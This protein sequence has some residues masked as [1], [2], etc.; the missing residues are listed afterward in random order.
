ME[1]LNSFMTWIFKSR[2]GQI[3]K[4]KQEPHSVQR[5][6]L[7]EL[8]EAAKH[9]EF[10]KTHHFEK[11]KSY[12]DFA[13]RVPLFDYESFTPYLEKNIKGKQQ[14]FWPSDIKWFA[15][16]SGTT[17]G[18]SKYI[19]VSD[20]SLEEC[21]YKGGKD[22]VSLY[23][24]NFPD[25]KV[26]TGKSLTVGGALEKD[27]LHPKGIARAGDVS[28]V[29]MHNLPI[30]AQFIRT[31]S[32]ETALMSDWEAKIERM[33]RETMDENVT[34]IAG[35]PTWTIVL[36]QRILELKKASHILE[37]WPNLEVFFHGAVA[38]GPYRNLFKELIPS[39]KMRYMETYNASEGFFG[40]QDQP[41][42]DELLLLL[43]YGIFY[44]FILTEDLEKENPRV[45]SL[46]GVEVGKNY[47]L[48]I[49]TNGGL[50]RYKIGD[51]VKFTSVLP[52]RFRIS[53]RT[54][55]FIN[56]FGEE[57]IVENAEAAISYACEQTGAT[58]TNFTAAPIYFEDSQSK[59]AHEWVVEFK[60][61]PSDLENFADILD[62]HLRE[63]NSDYD[64]K[65]H[66]NLALQRL[67]LHAAPVG[68]FESWLA[69]KGKLGGQHKVPR[70]SN[71]RE[72]MEEILAM[73]PQAT[74]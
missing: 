62:Q 9:T 37:V 23:V 59:G 49:S 52:Y 71:S 64:A 47:A 20:E 46:E 26:F 21:H 36:L 18:R 7:V 17:A 45:I 6:T 32:L 60:S 69:K 22:M 48:L 8:L 11:I 1:V 70:L 15:K 61:P 35:V 10:G 38:F 4:F 74:Q 33:A 30:W 5:T 66:K 3:E 14:V 54:K 42:S 31:P 50:W 43:D 13:K 44:E 39:D 25:T 65:R 34:S 57:V 41:D 24:S 51:T 58:L 56:A 19:P 27:L 53:G 55:H 16:S 2:L 67:Q 12:E 29:I 63:I 68:L 73:L 72:F 28:A 40:M